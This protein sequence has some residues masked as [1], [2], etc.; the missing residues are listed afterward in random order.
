MR[1]TDIA[2]APETVS[3]KAYATSVLR[4]EVRR[5]RRFG[6]RLYMADKGEE[7]RHVYRRHTRLLAFVI[8]FEKE[9]HHA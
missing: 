6:D 7:A 1:K 2:F 8:E 9:N 4:A 5:L 3:D